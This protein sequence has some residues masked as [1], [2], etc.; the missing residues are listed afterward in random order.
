MKDVDALCQRVII[1][2]HGRIVYDGSLSGIIDRFSSHKVITLLFNGD[3]PSGDLRES[4]GRYGE[5]LEL[6]PPKAKLRVDRGKV[7]EVLG[8]ILPKHVLEDVSVEDAP[9]EEVIASMFAQAEE[10]A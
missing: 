10:E 3:V 7:P 6:N 9:L 8:Q 5:V 1:I 4:L 2:A